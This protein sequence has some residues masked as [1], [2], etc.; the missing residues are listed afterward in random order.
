M[1]GSLNLC[2]LN[3]SRYWWQTA[4]KWLAGPV[5]YPGVLKCHPCWQFQYLCWPLQ[6]LNWSNG[7]G[8]KHWQK[9]KIAI[10]QSVAEIHEGGNSW[11]FSPVAYIL[12]QL[13]FLSSS[14]GPE[15]R[16]PTAERTRRISSVQAGRTLRLSHRKRYHWQVVMDQQTH[17]DCEFKL[18][19]NFRPYQLGCVVAIPP[20][21][22]H[23]TAFGL[24]SAMLIGNSDSS[25][26][27]ACW[28]R[29]FSRVFFNGRWRIG[30]DGLQLLILV[31]ICMMVCLNFWI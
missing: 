21:P 11:K 22:W 19:K 6:Y 31:S 24:G 16:Q 30:D 28:V 26:G 8:F 25:R 2:L 18:I 4:W 17:L 29:S 14:H 20:W 3:L 1:I 5:L 27:F 9:T 10:F 12:L 23:L 15:S 7:Y 13:C